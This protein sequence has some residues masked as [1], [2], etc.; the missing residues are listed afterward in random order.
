[1]QFDKA[2]SRV[3]MGHFAWL[4][5][6]HVGVTSV[7]SLTRRTFCYRGGATTRLVASTRLVVVASLLFG[8]A[9]IVQL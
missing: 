1:M 7:V 3:R 9:S 4:G 6:C 8:V 2:L 5:G